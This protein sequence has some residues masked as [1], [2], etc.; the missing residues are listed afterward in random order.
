V[1]DP[2]CLTSKYNKDLNVKY[3]ETDTNYYFLEKSRLR[4]IIVVYLINL[5][6]NGLSQTAIMDIIQE[7]NRS[8]VVYGIIKKNSTSLFLPGMS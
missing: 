5:R 2:S 6:D 8:R 1:L 3:L 4:L 7:S